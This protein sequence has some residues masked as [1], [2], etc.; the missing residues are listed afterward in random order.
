MLDDVS[1]PMIATVQ[2]RLT[3]ALFIGII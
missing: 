1:N 2:A 3:I